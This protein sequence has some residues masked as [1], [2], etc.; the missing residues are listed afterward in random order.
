M[1]N[2]KGETTDYIT[3]ELATR[4][5]WCTMHINAKKTSVDYD[6]EATV[7]HELSALTP[8]K[9]VESV[10]TSCKKCTKCGLTDPDPLEIKATSDKNGNLADTCL[11]DCNAVMKS[12]E[13]PTSVVNEM[14]VVEHHR[15][16]SLPAHC[17]YE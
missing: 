4:A 2:F 8:E 10:V 1:A 13:D 12:T 16:E 5:D 9:T 14:A 3:I 17:M 7:E 11:H 15:R 6:L